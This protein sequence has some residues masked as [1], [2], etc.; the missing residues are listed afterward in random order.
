MPYRVDGCAAGTRRRPPRSF[1]SSRRRP[2]VNAHAAR[3][4]QIPRSSTSASWSSCWSSCRTNP[5]PPACPSF[6]RRTPPLRPRRPRAGRREP[7]ARPPR[8][9]PRDP[10]VRIPRPDDSL[11]TRGAPAPGRDAAPAGS[12]RPVGAP[13]PVVPASP[14][15]ALT[16]GQ[17]ACV[18]FLRF[19][20]D[21]WPS[22]WE[23]VDRAVRADDCAAALDACLSVKSSAA[24]V[25]A[26][27]LSGVAS[28]LERAIRAN[29]PTASRALLP[30]LGEV[31]ERSMDAMRSWIRAEA[32][33]PPD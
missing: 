17:H 14:A 1:R 9:A 27:R 25:G 31:G 12:P 26:L 21:L 24:M 22:R 8:A 3:A 20:V 19:F 4:P 13:S 28:D 11:A 15:H 2:G 7:A 5:A 10:V 23:R 18:D 29:D 16:D 30:Q 6:P 33:P 32:G